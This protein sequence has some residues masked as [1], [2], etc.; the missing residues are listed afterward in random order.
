VKVFGDTSSLD[1]CPQVKSIL[2]S[3][4]KFYTVSYAINTHMI[5]EFGKL[6]EV[7]P[8]K[9]LQEWLSL[10]RCFEKIGYPVKTIPPVEGLP[11]LVFTANQSFPLPDGRVVLSKMRS[12][13]RA[14]EVGVFKTWY[15]DQ[16][17]EEFIEV[18]SFFESMGDVLWHPGSMLLWG[19]HGF[20]TE[21]AA[22]EELFD[23]IKIPIIPL[24]LINENFYHL[25]TCFSLLDSKTLAYYPGA[26]EEET[27]SFLEKWF[28][29]TI[30]IEEE[31]ALKNF[32]GNCYCPD[33][34]NV[35][36]HP[37]SIKFEKEL[38]K[39]GFKV[40]HV[41]TSEFIKGGGSVFCMKLPLFL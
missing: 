12:S 36:I 4:P 24:K 6:N 19:G 22:L 34:K 17:I 8:M 11:D 38:L 29:R 28:E 9:A 35:I 3:D 18:D 21:E 1:K 15:E 7:N 30:L 5:D 23:K 25:D 14:P 26:F 16:G 20:R 27:N 33:G 10:K 13:E 41:K 40:H 32:A 31:E 39:L 2:M 37:G